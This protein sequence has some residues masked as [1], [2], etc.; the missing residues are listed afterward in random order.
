MVTSPPGESLQSYPTV[1]GTA[2][3]G[4]VRIRGPRWSAFRY[5]PGTQGLLY[6]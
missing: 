3:P 2:P 6:L 5:A 1:G 4:A